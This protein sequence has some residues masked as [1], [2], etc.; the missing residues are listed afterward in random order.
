MVAN[1]EIDDFPGDDDNM[2]LNYMPDDGDASEVENDCVVKADEVFDIDND[3]KI[4]N[5]TLPKILLLV[6]MLLYGVK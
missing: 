1:D 4:K 5:R 3:E 6:R 2:D